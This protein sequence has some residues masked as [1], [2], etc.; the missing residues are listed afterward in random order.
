M[1]TIWLLTLFFLA[2]WIEFG[3]RSRNLPLHVACIGEAPESIW[4]VMMPGKV[5]IPTTNIV[6]SVGSSEA[7]I[8]SARCSFTVSNSCCML[9]AMRSASRFTSSASDS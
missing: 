8:A 7:R 9:S 5:T 1:R 6:L 3:G 4:P 2:S